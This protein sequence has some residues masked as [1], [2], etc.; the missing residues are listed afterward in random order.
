MAK[1][2]DRQFDRDILRSQ[3]L[4]KLGMFEQAEVLLL[5][6]LEDNKQPQIV[7]QILTQIY[8]QSQRYEDAIATLKRLLVILPSQLHLCDTL[9]NLYGN[10]QQWHNAIDC[11]QQFIRLNP[12]SA[13]AFFNLAYNLKQ[14][15]Q[16]QQSLKY[17]RLALTHKISQPEEVYLNMAV[18]YSDHLRQE[19]K[20][21]ESLEAALHINPH[22]VS[23]IYNL[24]NLYEEEGDKAQASELFTEVIRLQPT[25]YQALARLADVKKFTDLSDRLINNIK[26][27]IEVKNIVPSTKINLYYA[28][29]K[30][31]DDCRD[32]EQAFGCYTKAN[33]LNR[34]T[35]GTYERNEQESLI[36]RTIQL[37]SKDWFDQLVPISDAKLIFICGMFRSGSTLTEQILAAHPNVTAGGERDFFSRRQNPKD[38]SNKVLQFTQKELPILAQEYLK[39]LAE[40][41]PEAQT[42][43]DKR[44]DNYLYI[45]LIKSL[46]PN[47]RIIHS[48][49]NPLDNCLSVYFLRLGH[50][51]KYSTNLLDTAHYYQQQVR[52]MQHWKSLFTD[53]IFEIDYDKLIKQSDV[54]VNNLLDF[55]GL[56]WSD[57][58]LHFYKLNNRVKTASVWQ[59]RQPLYS[60]SSGRWCN[61]EHQIKSLIEHFER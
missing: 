21:K 54:Q 3:E 24:A 32:Y 50:A 9:A 51:M 33:Q 59:V 48:V 29:G 11:Y 34:L 45:G 53:S 28:L 56:Q 35:L 42:I 39:E 36:D 2:P 52:L 19:E 8:L 18:I 5:K 20:A 40:A 61:Y 38:G 22:F 17:Y 55:L 41:F 10:T 30:I 12:P 26:A 57:E 13:N 14:D 58:C 44:P 43:T 60:A 25:N 31:F 37:Y 47:A 15:C 46:F 49:R 16:F 1:H 23:A 7:L 6:L 4:F 27:A